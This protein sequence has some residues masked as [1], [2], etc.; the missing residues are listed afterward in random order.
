MKANVSFPKR[1]NWLK[2]L[3]VLISCL[4][5]LIPP[6]CERPEPDQE[7]LSGTDEMVA[8]PRAAS[9][10]TKM[11]AGPWNFGNG[12]G[13]AEINPPWFA[14]FGSFVLKVQNT[15]GG[16]AK[17]SKLEVTIDGVVII[18]ARGLAR[19]YFASKALRSLK[20]GAHLVVRL[21]GDGGCEVKV[22]IEGILTVGKVYG[23]HLYYLTRQSM[24]WWDANGHSNGNDGHL[25]IINDARENN[26]LLTLAKDYERYFWIGLTD[27]GYGEQHW[28]W[29]NNTQCRT[30]DWNDSQCGWPF[31][32][33]SC[34]VPWNWWGGN[35]MTFTDYGYNNWEGQEPNNGGGGCDQQNHRDENAAVFNWQGKWEDV[36]VDTY[37]WGPNPE[38]D[39]DYSRRTFVIEWDFIPTSNVLN[40]IFRNDYPEYWYPL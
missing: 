17:I 27:N 23:R 10:A 30:V 29:V 22:W 15:K 12:T 28:Y 35:C 14:H 34:P 5:F 26:F 8:T 36:T 21:E 25:V 37:C 11:F 24:N 6:A 39:C 20:N 32:P 2:A 38:T 18:T 4:L 13:G 31:D 7:S 9:T 3:G 33:T 40:D 1:T 16:E 19:D